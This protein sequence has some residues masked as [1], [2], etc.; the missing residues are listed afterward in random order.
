MK[1]KLTGPKIS[2]RV[3]CQVAMLIALTFVLE[4]LIPPVNIPTFR[5]SFAFIPM[6]CCGMLFGPLWGAFAYGISDLL[7]WP[8]MGLAPIPLVLVSRI[9]EGFIFGLFLHREN[10]KFAPHALVTAVT[11]QVVCA[12]GLTTLGLSLYFGAPYAG[13]LYSRLPQFAIITALQLAVFPLLVR[14][15]TVLNKTGIVSG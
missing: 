13:L 9:A 2:V 10:L 7:G 8:I 1:M 15:K 11:T 5:I 3:I 4:R 6:M 14:F 12:A